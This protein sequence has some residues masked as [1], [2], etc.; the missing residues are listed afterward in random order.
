[1][2]SSA[3]V[4]RA[5]RP[6]ADDT[7]RPSWPVPSLVGRAGSTNGRPSAVRIPD[8]AVGISPGAARRSGSE[9]TQGAPE[10]GYR[11]PAASVLIVDDCTLHRETLAAVLGANET[12]TVDLA[13]DLSSMST[14]L[15]SRKP[16]VILLSMATRDSTALLRT[17]L[18]I[19]PDVKVIVLAI[20]EDEESSIVA[21]AEAGVVGYHLLTDSLVDL[22]G[23]IRRVADGESMCSPRVSAILLRRLSQ[24][25]S[26]RLP[27]AAELLL[28]AREDQILRMLEIGLSNRE[29][30]A[31]LYIAVHTVKNHVHSVLSKL[32]VRTRAEAAAL[33][34]TMTRPQTATR[35]LGT[36]LPI[37][38]TDGQDLWDRTY[39]AGLTRHGNRRSGRG[40]ADLCGRPHID[41]EQPCP[42]CAG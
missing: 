41:E 10:N 39:R 34:R 2:L 33:S 3:A 42:A 12:A 32:G 7:V 28:T 6:D 19:R 15:Q 4:S 16:S 30:A 23:L 8:E 25:A 40:T 13:W 18:D 27:T 21:C 24:L 14:V 38:Y 22:L 36:G 35:E 37:G 5:R 29:I 9:L 1:M 11:I 17:A 26:Q 20:S 31:Q